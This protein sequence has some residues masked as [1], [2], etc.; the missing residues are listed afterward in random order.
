M[1][2][3]KINRIKNLILYGKKKSIFIK[4]KEIFFVKRWKAVKIECN[5]NTNFECTVSRS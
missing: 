5:G 4:I 3:K 1:K 2:E